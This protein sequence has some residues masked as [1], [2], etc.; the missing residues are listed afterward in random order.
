MFV[1]SVYQRLKNYTEEATAFFLSKT[2]GITGKL[3]IF[4][5]LSCILTMKVSF[6]GK[7]RAPADGSE[8]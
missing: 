7:G 4:G 5:D 3:L 1:G 2:P 6:D 8:I